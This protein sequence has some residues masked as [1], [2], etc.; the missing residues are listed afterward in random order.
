M[1]GLTTPAIYREIKWL[2]CYYM[3]RNCLCISANADSL[4]AWFLWKN[5]FPLDLRRFQCHLC[6]IHVPGESNGSPNIQS[7]FSKWTRDNQNWTS[8]RKTMNFIASPFLHI[9]DKLIKE[10]SSIRFAVALFHL[11]YASLTSCRILVI[12]P[13]EWKITDSIE[14]R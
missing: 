3:Y 13:I 14:S 9:H 8:R 11:K 1:V 5:H 10:S 12:H 4:T 7:D 2:K 6:W